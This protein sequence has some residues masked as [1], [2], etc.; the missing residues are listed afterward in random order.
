VIGAQKAGTTS[1]HH[2]LDAHPEI[3]M[4]R[5]KELYFFEGESSWSRGLEWYAS[6]FEDAPVRGE[7]CPGYSLWPRQPGVPEKISRV[8][9]D[10]LLVYLVR[11]PFDRIVSHWVHRT[12][13]HERA[14]FA[15]AVTAPRNVYVAASSYATQL[16]RY[17]LHFPLER[18]LVVDSDDLRGE[19]RETLRRIFRFVGVDD[20]FDSD[21]FESEHNVEAGLVR[22][23]LPGAVLAGALDRLVGRERARRLRGLVPDSA[24]RHFAIRLERPQVTVDLRAQLEET[25]GPEVERLRALTGQRFAG[26]SL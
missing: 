7:S 10:V 13:A 16:E 2:Y 15:E 20:S 26:W 6:Q 24:K 3:A 22:R 11:D 12:L 19:R 9:P 1:L 23:N 25:L 21:A 14:P 5:E 18:I 17:L 4:S 8:L